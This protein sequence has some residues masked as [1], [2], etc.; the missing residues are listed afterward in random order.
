[1]TTLA[2]VKET[3]LPQQPSV[4]EAYA[5]GWR[6]V[7]RTLSNG[8]EVRERVPLTLEDILHPEVGDYRMHALD[9]E[10]ICIYLTNV[11]EGQVKDDPQ[12]VVT[13]DVRVAWDDPD[14]KPHGPDVAVIFNVRMVK[15]W[16]TFDVVEERTQPT[17]IVEVTSP[18]TRSVDLVSKVDEYEWVGVP[19]YVIVDNYKHKGQW[20]RRLLAYTLVAG[21]YVILSPDERGWLWL[22]PLRLYLA[23]LADKDVVCYDAEGQLIGSYVDLQREKAEAEARAVEEKA[24]ADVAEAHNATLLAEIERLRA[25]LAR[26]A[27]ME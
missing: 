18:K 25:E 4:T 10:L 21:R 6:D 2:P 17:V 5:Y 8:E 1:M 22:E 23:V 24:R 16:S 26:N 9:H 19:L 15:N 20:R 27:G 13:H 12:A 3:N 11:F 7:V 14:I